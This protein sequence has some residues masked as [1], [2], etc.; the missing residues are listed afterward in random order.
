M[1][2]TINDFMTVQ[3]TLTVGGNFLGLVYGTYTIR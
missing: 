1:V 3:I 2:D